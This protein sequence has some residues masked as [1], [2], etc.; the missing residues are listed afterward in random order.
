MIVSLI[1]IPGDVIDEVAAV[2]AVEDELVL[3]QVYDP[4]LR[5]WIRLY[6]HQPC[7]PVIAELHSPLMLDERGLAVRA[8]GTGKER[9]V[10][11][12]VITH[13]IPAYLPIVQSLFRGHRY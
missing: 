9:I 8:N 11:M 6:L 1:S 7:C 12:L 2:W 10:D 3:C 5:G 4:T 13:T